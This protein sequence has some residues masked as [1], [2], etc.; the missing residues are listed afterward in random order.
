MLSGLSKDA[1]QL[2]EYMSKKGLRLWHSHLTKHLGIKTCAQLKAI[3][4]IDL[5]RMATAANMRLDQ[6]TIDQVLAA[7]RRTDGAQT[8]DQELDEISRKILERRVRLRA[9]LKVRGLESWHNYLSDCGVDDVAA[10]HR[11]TVM[12][13][14]KVTRHAKLKL[15]HRTINQ[16]LD[17]LQRGKSSG[18]R[19]GSSASKRRR[20]EAGAPAKHRT[21]HP[22]ASS[23]RDGRRIS[24]RRS[25]SRSR[26]RDGRRMSR[27]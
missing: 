14:C 18:P 16:V 9:Y 13:L 24:F 1:V 11:L 5:R 17:S 12:D 26:G 21:S 15:D 25:R 2:K 27:S 23:G 8:I 7:I 6:K 19:L 10:L 22:Q 3:T 20:L 4:A